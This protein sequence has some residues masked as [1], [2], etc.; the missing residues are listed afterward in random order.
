MAQV[1]IGMGIVASVFVFILMVGLIATKDKNKRVKCMINI[2]LAHI[3]MLMTD[4]IAYMFQTQNDNSIYVALVM[5]NLSYFACYAW[6]YFYH[7][8]VIIQL[9][10]MMNV[11]RIYRKYVLWV[12]I[13]MCVLWFISNWTG[14]FFTFTM[15]G[16]FIYS[17]HHFLSQ[18][19]GAAMVVFDAMVAIVHRRKLGR[20]RTISICSFLFF[21]IILIWIDKM[22][23]SA[24][25]M[26]LGMTASSLMFY[27][28][29]YQERENIIKENAV[30]IEHLNREILISQLQ[31]HFLVNTLTTI[32]YLCDTDTDTTKKAIKEFTSYLRTNIDSLNNHELVP[33]ES[34]YKNILSYMR[35]ERLRYSERLIIN[36]DG[37]TVTDFMMPTLILQPIVENAINHGVC[38]K[39]GG[40]TVFIITKE[41]SDCYEIIIKDNGVGFDTSEIPDRGGIA[42]SIQRLDIMC[43]GKLE[44]FSEPELGTRVKIILPKIV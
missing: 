2:F 22:V 29:L 8:M 26:Y 32:N 4:V 27:L 7:Q 42:N 25:P 3:I 17:K 14:F 41:K 20:R 10:E 34:E 38:K 44:V 1:N 11:N 28:F 5:V 24:F 9:E 16:D 43:S 33:F 12:C 18:D 19:V 13:I 39:V 35:L 21:A 6:I 15:K 37:V 36:T 40:G 30:E 31:P 23:G